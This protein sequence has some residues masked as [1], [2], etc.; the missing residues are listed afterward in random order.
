M[1]KAIPVAL[2]AEFFEKKGDLEKRMRSLIKK[3]P[4]LGFLEGQD[5]ELCLQLFKFH[6]NYKEKIGAGIVA[7]QV[8]IDEEHNTR[9]LHIH[10]ADGDVE[11]ISWKKC[12]ASIR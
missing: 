1:G 10:K 3:Y 5:Q 11:D 7:I 6:P 4:L 2:G 8:G 12:V 9:C